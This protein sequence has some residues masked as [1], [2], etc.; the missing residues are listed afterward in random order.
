MENAKEVILAK[1]LS[2]E[3]DDI[4]VKA[5]LPDI[6]LEGLREVLDEQ[7][8]LEFVLHPKESIWEGLQENIGGKTKKTYARRN[9]H[10]G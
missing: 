4:T 10:G 2:G 3:V 8:K 7:N 9:M 6:D 1:W 5:I